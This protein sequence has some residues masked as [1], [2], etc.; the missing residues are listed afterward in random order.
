MAINK[1]LNVSPY[2][3]DFDE[4]KQYHRVLFKP[5]RP[6]QARELT[7][8]QSVLQNQIERFGSNIFKEGTTI[9]GT[10]IYDISDLKYIKLDD[11]VAGINGVGLES[12]LPRL[13][14][15]EDAQNNAGVTEDD[16]LT[17]TLEGGTT[18]LVAEIVNVSDGFVTRN[19]DLKTFFIKYR[20]TTDGEPIGSLSEFDA[21]EELVIRDPFGATVGNITVSALAGFK[22][23]SRGVGVSDGVIFQKGHFLYVE[24]QTIVVSKYTDQADNIS[25]GFDVNELIVNSNQDPTLL[26]NSQGFLNKN[27]PGADRLRLQPFLVSYPS[28]QEP[29][30]FFALIRY[31]QGAPTQIRN[32]T[33]F[34]SIE[35]ELSRR[36]YDQSGNYV[37]RGLKC[38]LEGGADS[39]EVLAAVSPGTGY[40]NGYELQ[41]YSHEYFT[42]DP[43]EETNEVDSVTTSVQY[44]NYLTVAENGLTIPFDIEGGTIYN[45][46]SSNDNLIGTCNVRNVENGK[47]YIYNV[48]RDETQNQQDRIAR[49]GN[50]TNDAI[51]VTGSITDPRNSPMVFSAANKGV[52]EISEISYAKRVRLALSGNTPTSVVNLPYGGT[53]Q[54]INNNNIVV[55]NQLNQQVQVQSRTVINDGQGNPSLLRVTLTEDITP[56]GSHIYFDQNTFDVVPNS[57]TDVNMYIKTNLNTQYRRASLGVPDAYK[58]LSV[59]LFRTADQTEIGDVTEKFKLVTNQKDTMYDISYI[60]LKGGQE[61]TVE[62]GVVLL[63]NFKAFRH[64][65]TSGGGFFT[66]E[67]YVN[68][69]REDIPVYN[70]SNG[71]TYDLVSSFDF[72]PAVQTPASYSISPQS[73]STAID[74]ALLASL[75]PT[76]K[77]IESGTLISPSNNSNIRSKIVSYLSRIDQIVVDSSGALTYRKGKAAKTPSAEITPDLVLAEI[78]VPSNPVRLKGP[79]APRLKNRGIKAYTMR[80]ISNIESTIDR[81]VE[82][83]A[84]SMLKSSGDDMTVTDS[85]GLNRF[86]NGVAVDSFKNLKLADLNDP[87]FFAGIDQFRERATPPHKQFPIYLKRGASSNASMFDEI[88]TKAIGPTEVLLDQPA[89]TTYRNAVFGSF[90]Y[91]GSGELHPRYDSG[92]DMTVNPAPAVID[93]DMETPILELSDNIMELMKMTGADTRVVTTDVTQ[94]NQR[95]TQNGQAGTELVTR[96]TDEHTQFELTSSAKET[97]QV[98]GQFLTDA[99]FRPYMESKEIKILVYGLRPNVR[100]YFYF[101]QDDVNSM[102]K[103]G[104]SV[105]P[106]AGNVRASQVVSG[107]NYGDPVVSNSAGVLTAIFKLPAETYIVGDRKLEIASVDQYGAMSS[108]ADSYV[109]LTYSAHN[110]DVNSQVLT[111]NT[112]TA[113]FDVAQVGESFAVSNDFISRFTPDPPPRRRDPLAQTFYIQRSAV[114][115]NRYVYLDSVELFFKSK[116]SER[117][118]NI[119]IRE[120]INGY[121]ARQIVPFGKVHYDPTDEN[122]QDIINVSDDGSVGTTF[123]FSNPVR[124]ETEREYAVVIRPDAND[125]GYNLF[126][127]KLGQRDLVTN[128]SITAD[129]GDGVLFSSTNNLTWVP[130]AD[131]DLKFKVN[132]HTFTTD[133]TTVG[134]VSDDMEFFSISG[135]TGQFEIGEIAFVPDPTTTV[136]AGIIV[137]SPTI[138]ETTN[139]ADVNIQVGQYAL[140][141]TGNNVWVSKVVS[142]DGD[143][144]TIEE[145]S[146]FSGPT[147]M[148]KAVGGIVTQFNKFRPDTLDIRKSTAISG[149]AFIGGGTMTIYGATT[150]AFATIDSVNDVQMSSIQGHMYKAESQSATV[151]FDVYRGPNREGD[152]PLNDDYHFINVPRAIESK[153]NVILGGSNDFSIIANMRNTN[154]YTTPI[155]DDDVSMLFGYKYL[156]T[157]DEATTAKWVTRTVALNSDLFAE[158][159]RVRAGIHRPEGSD[160]KVYAK[161]KFRDNIEQMS[162]WILLENATPDLYSNSS[163]LYDYKEFD[164]NLPE[165]EEREFVSFKLKFVMLADAVNRTP[166]M[167]DYRAIAVT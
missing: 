37:S 19:P 59:K 135:V 34:N 86:K 38:N 128:R 54:P 96:I 100:H 50:D 112:R 124:L 85:A 9:S 136:S 58:L 44:G 40:S 90:K 45:L 83:S 145:P 161:F 116:S 61:I 117:G 43:V 95:G 55:I 66:A 110:F 88:I 6:V 60:E 131:E 89:A 77:L 139:G 64:D 146:P 8:L 162:D 15:K 79:Y 80:D 14:T 119:E 149:F 144:L 18:R 27:A 75:T 166:S 160:V 122:L 78:T 24:P 165:D 134:F 12:F 3:D 70:A 147:Q 99:N 159:L 154:E 4:T 35:K 94:F 107:G 91:I 125:P 72:R 93:I 126:T 1:D 111:V 67:S 141:Q 142:V 92:Y 11:D 137:A 115:D 167:I 39:N 164:F 150:G 48:R 148:T 104:A 74:Y 138:V 65:Y 68:V 71:N 118:V 47:I 97:N 98:V 20:G 42:V 133:A 5:A 53:T 108:A 41:L 25:V 158:G 123:R 22:G 62:V 156:V 56:S 121:P 84:L 69:P 132:I 87:E 49:I 152:L 103:P 113:E 30:N 26:D 153:S 52:K 51:T 81:L 105:L 57:K 32:V 102:V 127:A 13:A 129:W 163:A 130:H 155:I 157:N 143:R 73:A 76:Q 31:K 63:V 16:Y 82:L 151:D 10:D 106:S 46:Y 2:F 29:E 109:S 33:E 36:T 120:V 101:E 17:F 7:Q 28:D 114:Q 140:L 21:G 23:N